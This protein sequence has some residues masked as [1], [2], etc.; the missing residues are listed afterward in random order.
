MRSLRDR[1]KS[2]KKDIAPGAVATDAQLDGEHGERGLDAELIETFLTEVEAEVAG[3]PESAL[4]VA[5]PGVVEQ[6]PFG[7]CY[8]RDV[9]F[10]VL[11][12]HGHYPLARTRQLPLSVLQK[13]CK[14]KSADVLTWEDVCFFDTETTGLGS[15]AGN[16]I[17]LFG[18][19]FYEEDEFV[20]RQYFLREYAEERALLWS[21]GVLLGRFQAMVSFNGKGFDW[22]LLETRCTLAR[23]ELLPTTHLD[24]L[25]P[26]RRLWKKVLANCRLITLEQEVLGFAR[27]D[28]TPGAMAP[29]LYFAYQTD[30]DARR[31]TGIFT[32]NVHDILTLVTLSYHM[33]LMIEEPL[34]A[35]THPEELFGLSR[36][37]EE[38][39]QGEISEAC[40]VRVTE[41]EESDDYVREALWKLSLHHKRLQ[42]HDKAALLWHELLTGPALW[43]TAPRVELAKYYEHKVRDY[44]QAL[45]LTEETLE[46]V[47]NRK[48]VLRSLTVE[49]ELQELTHR[50]DRLMR[51]LTRE[52]STRQGEV[53]EHETPF[54]LGH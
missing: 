33:G 21:L 14:V 26:A 39:S 24:L 28:D 11:T 50:R 49:H 37:Y 17:F 27:V 42:R 20:V 32:H 54:T 13:V 16:F 2:Y 47:Q 22:K 3:L 10:D 34:H 23:M 30:L 15:G 41:M 25:P 38:W 7:P 40:L 48:L 35:A 6:T 19:G 53:P 9:R 46:L 29:E 43:Q 52:S 8:Y 36:W 1:L 44:Q 12:L 31:M 45:T 4:E 51:K 5:I 18:L